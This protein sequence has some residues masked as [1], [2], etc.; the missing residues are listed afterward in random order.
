[1]KTASDLSYILLVSWTRFWWSLY[2]PTEV[3][4]EVT[5]PS[6]VGYAEQFDQLI[7]S[8]IDSAKTVIHY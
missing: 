7:V 5:V 8:S 6:Y 4:S 3:R 2:S 1:M